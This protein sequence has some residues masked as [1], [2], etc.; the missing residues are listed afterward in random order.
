M[1]THAAAPSDPSRSWR[2]PHQRVPLGGA[3]A[4]VSA[5]ELLNA[6]AVAQPYQCGRQRAGGGQGG[7]D[8]GQSRPGLLCQADQPDLAGQGSA[9]A[10]PPGAQG[11]RHRHASLQAQLAGRRCGRR[12]RPA[13]ASAREPIPPLLPIQISHRA[14]FRLADHCEDDVGKDLRAALEAAQAELARIKK[15]RRAETLTVMRYAAAKK[16]GKAARDAFLSMAEDEAA[17]K[18]KTEG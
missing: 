7:E 13:R 11:H 15:L 1:S 2:A 6:C 12:A 17:A 10:R 8:A 3:C 9:R 4:V 5:L 18:M 14:C 16:A